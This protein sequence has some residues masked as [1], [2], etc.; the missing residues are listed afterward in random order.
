RYT[1]IYLFPVIDLDFN[2][3]IDK[4]PS[5]ITWIIIVYIK[6][7][8]AESVINIILKTFGDL[9]LTIIIVKV[10]DIVLINFNNNSNVSGFIFI[11]KK[12]N[13][14]LLFHSMR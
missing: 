11:I 8:L 5:F 10:L 12:I 14:L 9:P 2:H 3:H 6:G 1:L 7:I 4:F 13:H